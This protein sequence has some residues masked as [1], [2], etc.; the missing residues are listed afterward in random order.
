MKKAALVLIFVFTTFAI[1]AQTPKKIY[2]DSGNLESIFYPDNSD[3]FGT[4]EWV[5]YHENGNIRKSGK[6]N[7]MTLEGE[8]KEYNE[9]GVL[10]Q[11]MN[12]SNGIA[13]GTAKFYHPNGQLMMIG[14]LKNG[15]PTGKWTTYDKRGTVLKTQTL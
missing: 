2:G 5:Y 13:F 10:F 15:Q 11:I 6:T 7:N 4:G 9:N 1:T 12:Y 8:W 14:K 3:D